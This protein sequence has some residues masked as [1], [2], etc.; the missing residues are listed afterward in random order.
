MEGEAPGVE[1]RREVKLIEGFKM[2]PFTRTAW[3]SSAARDTWAKAI[4]DCSQMVQELEVESVAAGQRPCS[5]QTMR[6]EAL[7]GFAERC[8][9]KGLVVLPVQWIGDFE[10]F[11]HYTPQG[12]SSVYCIV[13]RKVE[14]AIKF[15]EAFAAGDHEAQGEMLGFPKCCREAFTANWKAGVFDPIW[16]AA[17]A[18]SLGAIK[19]GVILSKIEDAHPYSNPLLRYVGLRVGFHIPHSFN[20]AETVASGIERLALAKDRDLVKLLEAL[21]SMPMEASLLFGILTV[22]TPIFYLITYSVPTADE[23]RIS[24]GGEF[25]PKEG[26]WHVRAKR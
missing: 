15:R 4:R 16:Q 25:I 22:R 2:T 8:A 24:I 11:I 17:E 19:D 1:G 23:Y 14:E 21:L 6:R 13:A 12:D 18:G 20:C 3:V 9:K 7:P 5:W 26:A 10:G